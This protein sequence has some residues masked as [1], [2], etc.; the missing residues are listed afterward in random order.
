MLS[1]SI[2][3]LP[4]IY[5][6]FHCQEGQHTALAM[7]HQQLI[8]HALHAARTVPHTVL[9]HEFRSVINAFGVVE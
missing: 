3:I 4:L 1:L 5:I 6:S 7:T 2:L 8:T 9:L